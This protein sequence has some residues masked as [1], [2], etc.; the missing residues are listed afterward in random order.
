MNADL[1]AGRYELLHEAPPGAAG[2]L[3]EARDAET[4]EV[5]A[6]KVF[7]R[8]MQ[9]DAPELAD[10]EHLFKAGLVCQHPR[11]VRFHTLSLDQ[12]YLAREWIHG[13]PLID[14]LRRRRELP[15]A[16]V[17]ALFHDVPEMI[18]AAVAADLAP[19][20]DLLTRLFV[21]WDRS[22][23]VEEL[24]RL[25]GV[26][27]TDWSDFSVK[28]NPISLSAVLPLSPEETMSTMVAPLLA[29][30]G[31]MRTPSVGFAETIHQLLGAPRRSDRHRRYVPLGTLNEAGNAVLRRII[32]GGTPPASCVAFWKELID[33]TALSSPLR[34]APPPPPPSPV[35]KQP[36]PPPL[37]APPKSIVAPPPLPKRRALHIPEAFLGHVQPGT[38]LRLTP[39]DISFTPIQFIARPAFRIGRSLYHSDFVTRVLPETPENEKLTKEI[40]RVHALA[41]VRGKQ[42]VLRDGNGEQASVNGS[43]LNEQ[44]LSVDKPTPLSGRGVLALYR[45]YE[46][47]IEPMLGSADLGWTIDNEAAWPGPMPAA[48]AI[49]GAVVFH[50]R[51]N[52]PMLRQSA[53]LF[54]R[55]D[56]S[57]SSR[58]DVTWCEAGAP[59]SQGSFIHHRGCFWLATFAPPPGTIFLNNTEVPPGSAVPLA[60]GQPIQ[61]GP[62]GYIVEI[63]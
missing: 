34:K 8:E 19:T 49:S 18:D 32:E 13:F 53:W 27:V 15:A 48:P 50:P 29:Q 21:C 11:I 47:E 28:L 42:I 9:H 62:G 41:E 14:L 1:F 45:N 36:P 7:R 51:R 63:Q 22:I 54:T 33:A 60:S 61:L 38:I 37:P 56:F 52:Q 35:L 5:V 16:E 2:R 12:G 59:S 3:F 6:L 40:G 55:L 23:P 44:L 24:V 17:A 57:L 20:G 26:P 30:A 39:R 43:K 46:L 58:G 4:G 31:P 25:R 10:I